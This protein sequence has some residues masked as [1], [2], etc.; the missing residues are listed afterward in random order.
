MKRVLTA[1]VAANGVLTV[2][3]G[4]G[5]ANK[6]VR[7]TVETLEG[8]TDLAVPPDDHETWRRFLERTGGSITDATFERPPQGDFEQ[9]DALS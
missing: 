2:P 6:D 4:K 8:K 9:R 7:V 5:E 3:L 1:R